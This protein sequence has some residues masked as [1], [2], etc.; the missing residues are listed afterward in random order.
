MN[1]RYIKQGIEQYYPEAHV[2]IR[3]YAEEALTK[4]MLSQE[5][6]PIIKG[7]HYAGKPSLGG[8]A[9]AE[10]TQLPSPFLTGTIPPQ[11]FIRWETQR[12]CPFSCSFCQHKEADPSKKRREFAKDRIT[13]EID[14]IASS[15]V[16]DIA[17]LDPTFNS[18]ENYLHVLRQLVEKRFSGKI[19]LQCRTEM[20]KPEFLDLVEELNRFGKVVLEFG[21][22]TIHK[23]E[24]RII[25]RP[26]NLTKIKTILPE[27]V[28]RGIETEISLIFG[29]PKQTV[30]SFQET[31]DFCKS[32]GVSKVCAFPLMLLRGTELYD[33]KKELDLVESTDMNFPKIPRIQE[34]IPHVV[35]SPS[36]TVDEWLKMGEMA[37]ALE[38]ENHSK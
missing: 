14:W 30:Q 3:G 29:L 34:G 9:I 7:I 21:L 4:L 15:M 20:V 26:N 11:S 17:V 2:F 31:I 24:M 13:Q 1:G 6:Y 18:G 8:S 23:E 36:F 16:K 35:A 5:E 19:S 25:Q 37:E 22:Q 38:E 28:R 10:L 33:R 27:V 32:Y 12:G